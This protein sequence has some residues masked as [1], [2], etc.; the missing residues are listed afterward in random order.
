MGVGLDKSVIP[1]TGHYRKSE[2]LYVDS[3][4]YPVK[5]KEFP[6]LGV[7]VTKTIDGHVIA[8]P[9]ATLSFSGREGY[10]RKFTFNGLAELVKDPTARKWIT[11]SLRDPPIRNEIFNNVM[12]SLPFV[13]NLAFRRA[14][15][16]IYD[17]EI[18]QSDLEPYRPGIRAQLVDRK[19]GKMINDFMVVKG[20]HS[21]S[22]M[23]MNSPG[24]SSCL[25][26]APYFVDKYV[27]PRLK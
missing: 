24:M 5:N 17:G 13:G 19:T 15:K 7:H 4:I 1:I 18:N 20:E 12:F 6:Q 23:N 21:V 11:E 25:A 14:I 27:E 26:I 3:M 10:D 8:G 22:M 2:S 16:K 9:T